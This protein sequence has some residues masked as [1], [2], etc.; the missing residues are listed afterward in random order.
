LEDIL[1]VFEKKAHIFIEMGFF[2]AWQIE[3]LLSGV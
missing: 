3:I 1:L 2:I